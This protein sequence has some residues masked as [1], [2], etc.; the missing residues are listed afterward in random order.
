MCWIHPDTLD[1]GHYLQDYV[2]MAHQL[3]L[4]S[5]LS[6]VTAFVSCRH[7]SETSQPSK[8]TAIWRPH[9][10][11]I[12][13]LHSFQVTLACWDKHSKYS[14]NAS[15]MQSLSRCDMWIY[16]KGHSHLLI[17]LSCTVHA[18]VPSLIKIKQKQKQNGC[19]CDKS[20]V[21]LDDAHWLLYCLHS[22]LTCVYCSIFIFIQ[23][24]KVLNS[25]PLFWMI[26]LSF[27]DY[28]NHCFLSLLVWPG[29]WTQSLDLSS[30][31]KPR[32]D[33]A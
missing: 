21:H 25:E 26:W 33:R 16:W 15:A 30:L 3:S 31:M 23:R 13:N 6:S 18:Q 10:C 28:L 12:A 24:N 14:F 8:S 19:G 7:E 5:G 11:H 9:N 27:I 22:E 4:K 1:S 29:T 2:K 20:I 32:D 17:T